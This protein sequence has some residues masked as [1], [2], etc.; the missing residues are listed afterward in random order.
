[1][2]ERRRRRG[3]LFA[4]RILSQSRLSPVPEEDFREA[5]NLIV[6]LFGAALI[7]FTKGLLF[8]II[9]SV[10]NFVWGFLLQTTFGDEKHL[11]KCEKNA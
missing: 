5:V 9:H 1:M 6:Q 8:I 4:G 2:S 11:V 10:I 7:R 3:R